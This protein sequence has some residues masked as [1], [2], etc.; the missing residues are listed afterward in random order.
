[1]SLG[2]L[3]IHLSLV[4]LPAL[5]ESRNKCHLVLIHKCLRA[6]LH[7][8]VGVGLFGFGRP[9]HTHCEMYCARYKV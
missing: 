9:R 7:A 2:T 4:L 1:M 3:L 6:L 5:L 8:G